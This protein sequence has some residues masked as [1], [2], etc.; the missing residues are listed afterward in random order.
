MGLVPESIDVVLPALEILQHLGGIALRLGARLGRQERILGL[1]HR[2]LVLLREGVALLGHALE[3]LLRLLLVGLEL[4][5]LILGLVV[6][7]EELAHVDRDDLE[8]R[9]G[10]KPQRGR[11]E[12]N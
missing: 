12:G 1:F 6:A 10:G 5:R 8:G 7:L 11:A 3:L 9:L 2:L 4:G